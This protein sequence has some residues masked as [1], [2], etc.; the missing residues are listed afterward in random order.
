MIPLAVS[1]IGGKAL[2]PRGATGLL[3]LGQVVP[4]LNVS[5]QIGKARLTLRGIDG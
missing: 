4:G 1:T 2:A 5:E 3:A